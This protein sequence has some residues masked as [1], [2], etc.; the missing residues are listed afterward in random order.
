[1]IFQFTEVDP[2]EELNC[3]LNILLIQTCFQNKETAV[4]QSRKVYLYKYAKMKFLLRLHVN[5][6]GSNRFTTWKFTFKQTSL[7][8]V[9][10]NWTCKRFLLK[11]AILIK[12][13]TCSKHTAFDLIG[14]QQTLEHFSIVQHRWSDDIYLKTSWT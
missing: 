10:I 4:F 11:N 13:N 6:E 7:H 8:H 9:H 5:N 2:P 3:V 1:M 12:T 14:S